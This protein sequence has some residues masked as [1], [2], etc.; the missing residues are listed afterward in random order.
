MRPAEDIA[1]RLGEVPGVAAVALGGSW[2]RGEAHPDSDV[3]LGL[4]YRPDSP[5][6]V[7]DL[8]RLARELDDRHPPDP[9]SEI[10]EWGPWINGGG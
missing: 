1:Q 4:Y 8:R 7:G 9:V 6:D 5:P 3:D 10:G 2:A